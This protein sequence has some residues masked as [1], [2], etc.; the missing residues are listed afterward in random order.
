MMKDQTDMV[1][2]LLEAY[3]EAK[4]TLIEG[5]GAA[6]AGGDTG[7]GAPSGGTDAVGSADPGPGNAVHV[8]DVLGHCHHD[9]CGKKGEGFLGPGCFHVPSRIGVPFH[10]WELCNG[11]SKRKKKKNKKDK[12]YAYE[13]GMKIIKSY[14]DL[15]EDENGFDPVLVFNIQPSMVEKICDQDLNDNKRFLK[16]QFMKLVDGKTRSTWTD[17]PEFVGLFDRKTKQC[18]AMAA[19]EYGVAGQEDCFVNEVQSFKKGYGKD[20]LIKIF[21]TQEK[22]WLGADPTATEDLLK[23]YRQADFDLVEHVVDNAAPG[24]CSHIFFTQ[25]CDADA[26]IEWVDAHYS[27]PRPNDKKEEKK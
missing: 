27:K 4:K 1:D 11:G 2:I 12:K 13:K 18:L 20:L 23:Y 26:L 16:Q 21:D 3:K 24:R 19:L 7:G 10:R 5:E 14:D 22:V 25:D 6:C 8:D 9:G 15:V 17:A